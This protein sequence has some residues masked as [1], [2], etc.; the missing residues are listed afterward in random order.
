LTVRENTER[1]ITI[2]VGTNRLVGNRCE[3]LLEAVDSSLHGKA[4]P[5]GI[6]ELWD[7]QASRR[8]AQIMSR[9]QG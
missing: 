2:T 1:P 8:I 4:L 9:L 6:P 3:D 7:G 5:R